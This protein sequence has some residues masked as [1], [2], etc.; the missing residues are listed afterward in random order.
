ME[1]L[2]DLTFTAI[3]GIL[4]SGMWLLND[5][6]TYLKPFGL[7]QARLSIL[8][9]IE[10]SADGMISPHEIAKITGKSRPGITR[11]IERLEKDG[12]LSIHLNTS[13]GRMKHLSMTLKGRGLLERIN[14]EYSKHIL[15][16]GKQLTDNDKEQLITLLEKLDFLDAEKC[17]RRFS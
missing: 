12:L 3:F 8:L 10:E 15:E 5:L 13:D 7:S 14:P 11:M 4:Q 17:L 6:E 2:D 9:A 1:K 16:M